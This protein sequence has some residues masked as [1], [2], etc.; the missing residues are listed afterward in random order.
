MNLGKWEVGT[1]GLIFTVSRQI[2]TNENASAR[3]WL[4]GPYN[5]PRIRLFQTH[6][7]AQTVA[8]RMNREPRKRPISG[9][10]AK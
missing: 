7:K 9:Q 1:N 3:K 4:M 10:V 6:E 8:D 5:N 2:R